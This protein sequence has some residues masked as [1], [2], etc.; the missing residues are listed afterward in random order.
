MALPQLKD[1]LELLVKRKEF[2]PVVLGPGPQIWTYWYQSEVQN[3]MYIF[4]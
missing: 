2:L 4:D 3:L 1:P